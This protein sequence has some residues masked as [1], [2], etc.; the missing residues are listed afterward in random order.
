MVILLTQVIIYNGVHHFGSQ[1]IGAYKK[2]CS[3]FP[4]LVCVVMCVYNENNEV[5]QYTVIQSNLPCRNCR[6]SYHYCGISKC[7]YHSFPFFFSLLRPYNICVTPNQKC[8][9]FPAS[10]V[11]VWCC[12]FTES[13]MKIRHQ[14]GDYFLHN[15]YDESRLIKNEKLN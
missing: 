11:V 4:Y 9:E 5:K 8:F 2:G 13:L 1:N 3:W 12:T 14:S 15:F 6:T 7:Q 10:F